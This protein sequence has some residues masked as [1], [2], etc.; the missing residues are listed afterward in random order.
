M[1]KRIFKAS[2]I[3]LY[4]LAFLLFFVIGLYAAKLSGAGKDQMLAGGAIVLFWGLIFAVLAVVASA[5]LALYASPKTVVRI[6]WALLILVLFIYGIALYKISTRENND[7]VPDPPSE[8]T[9]PAVP[10]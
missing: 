3:G 2:S 8:T 5:V 1:V 7:P 6:N 9:A 10:V 4:F